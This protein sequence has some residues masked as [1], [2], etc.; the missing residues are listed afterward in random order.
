MSWF[1]DVFGFELFPPAE[2]EES[3][4]KAWAAELARTRKARNELPYE[5][6]TAASPAETHTGDEA[7]PPF[8]AEAVR[9]R[10][11]GGDGA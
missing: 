4:Q 2:S 1:N 6:F 8:N 5:V 3:W 7:R 10:L 11:D 9:R